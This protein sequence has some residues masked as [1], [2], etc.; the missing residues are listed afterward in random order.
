MAKVRLT[1]IAAG[2]L[3]VAGLIPISSIPGSPVPA[4]AQL[5]EISFGFNCDG[6][7]IGVGSSTPVAIAGVFALTS[8]T[9]GIGIETINVGGVVTGPVNF[10][11][12]YKSEAD[13]TFTTAWT[14]KVGAQTFTQNFFGGSISKGTKFRAV[15]TDPDFPVEC[16]AETQ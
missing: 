9:A 6:A 16:T 5:S 13:G 11:A 12:T 10:T 15:Q 2:I 4:A 1:L 8:A 7:E 14:Y 3:G